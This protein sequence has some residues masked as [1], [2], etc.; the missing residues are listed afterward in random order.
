MAIRTRI[1]TVLAGAAA[2]AWLPAATPTFAQENFPSRPIE[3]IVTFGPGGGADLMGRQMSQIL[4]PI[5]GTSIPVTNVAGASGNAGLTR[6]AT[7]PADGYTLG[8]LISLT[9]ASW[10]SELGDVGA[11]D[12]DIIAV[13]QNTPSMLFVRPQSGFDTVEALFDKARQAPGTLT[14]ATSGYGTQDDVTVQILAEGGVE[15]SNVPFAAPAER[16]A[17]TVGGHTDVLYEEPGDIVQFLQ[18][19]QLVPLVVFDNERHPD[20]P[21]VPTAGEIGFDIAGLYTFRS[22]AA[23][24]GTP[25]DVIAKLE[26]AIIEASKTEEWQSFCRTTYTCIDP[27]TGDEARQMVDDFRQMIAERLDSNR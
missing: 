1:A 7:S 14:V 6:L 23:P 4:E 17:S 15:M 27:V 10:A 16:Y 26:E 20:F 25:D 13:I 8:T 5:L 11:D 18:S 2:L 19:G 21:D 3:L 9:V 22:I 12:F 24:A